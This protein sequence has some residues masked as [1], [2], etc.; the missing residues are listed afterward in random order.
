MQILVA[1]RRD[2]CSPMPFHSA[3]SV[4]SSKS[5]IAFCQEYQKYH[6]LNFENL[7]LLV[8]AHPLTWHDVR[9]TYSCFRHAAYANAPAQIRSQRVV[10]TSPLVSIALVEPQNKMGFM[11]WL[12]CAVLLGHFTLSDLSKPKLLHNKHLRFFFSEVRNA[13]SSF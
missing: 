9:L 2:L 5:T 11:R 13:L 12:I 6:R 4:K 3:K 8:V 7:V 10:C 1:V